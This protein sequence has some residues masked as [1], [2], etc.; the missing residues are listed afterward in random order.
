MCISTAPINDSLAKF[1][2]KGWTCDVC[3]VDNKDDDV[4]C[5]ACTAPKPGLNSGRKFYQIFLYCILS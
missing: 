4:K 5:A 1:V 2:A 3:L